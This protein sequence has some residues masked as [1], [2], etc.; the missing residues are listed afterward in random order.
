MRIDWSKAKP[1]ANWHFRHK[2]GWEVFTNHMHKGNE[3][4][5][6][7][8]T[9]RDASQPDDAI[10]SLVQTDAEAEMLEQLLERGSALNVQ[11]GGRHYKDYAIQ[12]V[13]FIHANGIGYVEGN[14]IKYVVRWRRKN[15]IEDL[16]KARHYIDLL[17][18]L[19]EREGM[20]LDES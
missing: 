7:R 17:I 8:W 15:G 12:P 11:E 16:K 9:H 19:E 14:V 18:E 5:E 2:D 13:E 10:R 4:D 1:G 20:G 6:G 3:W